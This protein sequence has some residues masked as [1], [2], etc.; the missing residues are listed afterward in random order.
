M[1]WSFTLP[2]LDGDQNSHKADL[3]WQQVREA[4]FSSCNRRSSL[5]GST[6]WTRSGIWQR[7]HDVNITNANR[8]SAQFGIFSASAYSTFFK[9]YS[10]VKQ[11]NTIGGEEIEANLVIKWYQVIL[12]IEE[13]ALGI[14]LESWHDYFLVQP[15]SGPI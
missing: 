13:Y 11:E 9:F 7:A 3:C 12:I 10:D 1:L 6:T 14:L 2:Q 8:S 4:S 15:Q 5:G